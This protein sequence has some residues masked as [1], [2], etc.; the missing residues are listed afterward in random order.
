M[1]LHEAIEII[2]KD[3]KQPMSASELAFEL[4][5]L[6]LY[7]KADGSPISASQISARVRKY[8]DWFTKEGGLIYRNAFNKKQ[9]AKH[10]IVKKDIPKPTNQHKNSK[11]LEKLLLNRK[12]FKAPS[13]I[14]HKVPTVPGIYC[15]RIKDVHKLPSP[16]KQELEKREHD[17]I[18][19]GIASKSLKKRMLGQELRAKG[20][21]TFF[22]SIGAV[23]GYLP[24][25]GSLK[26]RKNIR[27]YKFSYKDEQNI[28]SW[29]NTNLLVNWIEIDG[30]LNEMETDLI[31]SVKPLL[32]ISK[33]T[34]KLKELIQL[35]N[36]CVDWANN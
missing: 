7:R 25:K 4:N 28:I 19:L 5:R 36:A 15:F 31:C 22:R 9:K 23:L 34:Y 33:N 6:K 17:I 1:I 8:P 27:N 20:N 16:F 29:I 14:D 11:I 2:L 30:L 13:F 3:A 18:Y 12:N 35:R 32:N 24:E 10:V 26:N 21:G